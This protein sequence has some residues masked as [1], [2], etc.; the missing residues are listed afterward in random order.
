MLLSALLISNLAALGVMIL[1]YEVT[2]REG[3]SPQAAVSSVFWLAFT[4]TAFFLF[5]A[6]T[7]S[8]FLFLV[9]SAWLAARSRCWGLA[10]LLAGLAA[11][12]RLQGALLTP[13]FLWMWLSTQ[14]G[15]SPQPWTQLRQ[16]WSLFASRLGRRSL[17]EAL[18]KPAWLGCLL[19]AAALSAWMLFLELSRLGTIQGNLTGHWGIRVVPPWQGFWLFLVRLFT[20]RRVFVDYVDLLAVTSVLVIL[21]IA[22]RRLE[23]ALSLYAWLSL[24]LFFMRGTP[25]HLLDS[26]SRYMLSVFPVFI[27]L[28]EMKSRW[29]RVP[30]WSLAIALQVFLVMGFLD[31]RW[32]A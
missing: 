30:A 13:V 16:V 12:C 5:A 28:G 27:P 23:P 1:L 31:W 17:S 14:A 25:P 21:V 7:D 9:L 15:G 8:L 26:F 2:L 19:P 18:R 20:T 3:R 6:Y 24:G 4:P 11:L 22:S 32:V 29:V 10:G